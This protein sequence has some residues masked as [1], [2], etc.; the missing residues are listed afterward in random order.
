MVGA[1]NKWSHRWRVMRRISSAAIFAMSASAGSPLRADEIERGKYLVEALT[2][3]DNC[4]TPR[5][6]AGYDESQ[7]F[8]GGSQTFA[9]PGYLTRGG[10]ISP[11]K[12]SGTGEWTDDELKAAIVKGQGKAGRLAP[13]MPSDSYAAMS[14]RDLDA[15]V[16]YLRSLPPVSSVK[17]QSEPRPDELRRP[18][19]PGAEASLA[20][21]VLRDQ[22]THGLYIAS[23]A[24]CMACHSGESNDIPDYVNRLGAGGKIF[25]TP[26]GVAVASN[27]SSHPQ[28]G[29]GSWTDTEVK[30]AITEGV[31][32]DG[33][34]LKPTM[35]NLSKAHFSKMSSEDLDALVVWLRAL[36]PKE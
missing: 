15:I 3:C 11:D 13:Y 28:K 21:D 2:A 1:C 6:P 32:R 18:A 23:L 36:P 4:H 7:R 17:K 27:I 29:I 16:S 14:N 25:R 35:A 33:R 12:A 20:D 31:S 30:R 19:L 5:N 9:G 24:R 34:V 10:N 26:A 8:S 22:T